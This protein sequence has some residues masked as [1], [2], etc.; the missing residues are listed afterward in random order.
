VPERTIEDRLREE[1]FELLPEVQRVVLQLE[2]EVR[3]HILRI[4]QGLAP[5][6]QIVVK[7]RVKECESAV[8]A[9][10]RRQEGAT[11]D[12]DRPEEYS[13]LTLKDLAGVRVL[14]FPPSRVTEIDQELQ[15]CFHDWTSDPIPDE[16]VGV[17]AP[18]YYGYCPMASNRVRGEFQI[19]SMLTGLFW[20][21]EH[22]AIYKP[23]PRLKGIERDLDMRDLTRDVYRA[24]SRFEEGYE[25]L[26]IESNA[27]VRET[28]ADLDTGE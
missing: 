24:L 26:V 3:S 8:N 9:L 10:R 17:L 1:Y 25:R 15:Q 6:E 5:H 11:F 16:G 27:G 7:S 19:V 18:K 23:N 13:L 28:D 12:R 20:E 21:V 2:T 14:A 22:A 4:Q